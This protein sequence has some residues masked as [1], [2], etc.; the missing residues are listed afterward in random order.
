MGEGGA[1]WR[2][3]GGYKGQFYGSL[4]IRFLLITRKAILAAS[5]GW[6]FGT[7]LYIL[8]L[9]ALFFTLEG[10]GPTNSSHAASEDPQR[11]FRN[12]PRS[13][14]R[15]LCPSIRGICVGIDRVLTDHTDLSAAGS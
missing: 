12:G 14:F 13:C 10:S 4:F 2:E 15:R 9:S 1:R 5:C 7:K 11:T 6:L 3:G 8:L